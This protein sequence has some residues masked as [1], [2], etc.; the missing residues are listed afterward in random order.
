MWGVLLT[1]ETTLIIIK[2]DGVERGLVGEVIGRF[3]RDGFRLEAATHLRLSGQ[4]AEGF[5]AEH[6]GKEFFPRLIEFTTSGPV[7]VLALSRE[8][9]IERARGLVGATNPAQAAPG[10]M[11]GDF[12]LD[13]TRNTVHA[14]DSPESARREVSFFFPELVGR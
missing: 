8:G 4:Q 11:R 7:L 3:E 2:P 6:R 10:T 5:Y 13:N 1:T 9:A 12:G 14:S